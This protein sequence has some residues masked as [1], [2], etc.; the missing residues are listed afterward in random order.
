M[1]IL[2]NV[3]DLSP[4]TAVRADQGQQNK[5]NQ[6]FSDNISKLNRFGLNETDIGSFNISEISAT[7]F[8]LIKLPGLIQYNRFINTA[9]I[10]GQFDVSSKLFVGSSFYLFNHAATPATNTVTITL[11]G[12]TI[13]GSADTSIVLNSNTIGYLI[14]VVAT[15][16]L[17]R[18]AINTA[19]FNSLLASNNT[20]SGTNSFTSIAT[21]TINPT[22]T[23]NI[24]TSDVGNTVINVG[25]SA[26]TGTTPTINF[27][28][29]VTGSQSYNT[30]IVNYSNQKLMIGNATKFLVDFGDSYTSFNNPIYPASDSAFTIGTAGLRWTDIYAT[31]GTINTSDENLKDRIRPSILGLEFLMS[32]KPVSYKWKDKEATTRKELKVIETKDKD[33]NVSYSVEEREV[34]KP[35]QRFKRFHYGL[36]N[37]DV[38]SSLK[39]FNIDTNDFA[40]YVF[41]EK[42]KIGGLRYDQF[43]PITI[44]SI[45]EQQ[46]TI[47]DLKAQ[48]DDL[49]A[50]VESLMKGK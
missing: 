13:Y 27:K 41:D 11:N 20:W 37:Q 21:Q 24:G 9:P 14:V 2:P 5:L 10:T 25:N 33:D 3:N 48:I 18:I 31:N 47:Q 44:K 23:L 34:I 28:F 45:Q 42:A 32:L 36:L 6:I 43:I 17:Q 16:V 29:G 19:D 7:A 26:N 4:M 39:Q 49:R 15:G 38:L 35:E 1:T 40:G 8:T 30:Q 12:N 22:G 50:M 46:A